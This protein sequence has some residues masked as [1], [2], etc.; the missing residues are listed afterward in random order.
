MSDTNNT[1]FVDFL[2]YC[3]TCKYKNLKESEEPCD[4][5]LEYPVNFDSHKPVKWEKK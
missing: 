2:T 3:E 4:I 5:C 1:K